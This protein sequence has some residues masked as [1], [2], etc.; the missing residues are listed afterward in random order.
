MSNTI[1]FPFGNAETIALTATGDQAV[2][3]TNPYTIIDG[4]TVKSTGHRT[5]NLT[6]DAKL[7]V[8]ALLKVKIQYGGAHNFIFGTKITHETMTGLADTNKIEYDFIFDG[9]NFVKLVT[10]I[11]A[12]VA[13]LTAADATQT[14]VVG[15]DLTVVDGV[16]NAAT[17][18]R[19]INL[20][21][22]HNL[23]PWKSR[24]IAS[25]K[26]TGA[27][28]TLTFGTG[29][30]GK[31]LT[32]TQDKTMLSEFVWNGTAFVQCSAETTID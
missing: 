3:V 17:A 22:N 20:T 30:T 4:D 27:A 28:R 31:P 24:L 18:G 1:K 8:G 25:T 19:T 16:T 14:V 7:Q 32:G 21:L 23:I 6:L 2:T 5:L 12:T 9:T 26:G 29:I 11:P 13:V 15:T 10:A